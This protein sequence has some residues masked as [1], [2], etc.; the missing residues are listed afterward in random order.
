MDDFER[1]KERKAMCQRQLEAADVE[2]RRSLANLKFWRD[3]LRDCELE[4]YGDPQMSL[5]LEV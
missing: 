3:A 1:L 5:K 2:C 4:M